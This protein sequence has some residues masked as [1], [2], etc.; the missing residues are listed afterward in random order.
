MF[1]SLEQNRRVQGMIRRCFDETSDG[2]KSKNTEIRLLFDTENDK[3]NVY[4]FIHA[5]TNTGQLNCCG[6]RN[7]SIRIP[8]HRKSFLG[9]PTK[10]QPLM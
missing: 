3:E 4:P 6:Q 8:W 7:N 1:D 2:L 5:Y 10:V 9:R